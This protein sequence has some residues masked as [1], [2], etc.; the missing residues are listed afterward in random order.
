MVNDIL[1][2][3]G[4]YLIGSLSGALI[5]CSFMGLPDPRSQ[6]SG[7]PGA[8]NV[9]RHSG[10]TAAIFTLLVDVVKGVT[11]VL[12]AKFFTSSALILAST[13]LAVV[14]GHLYPLFFHFKGGKG[15]A[16]TFGA[17]VTL[18]WP[19]GL[20]A[21]TT[22]LVMAGLFRYSSLAALTAALLTPFYMYWFT[23]QIEYISLS[24]IL[25][26]LLIWRHRSNIRHLLSGQE[27]KF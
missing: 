24:V 26:S 15:V 5:V 22:W 7:N 16:T 1:L 13:T 10:K 23:G 19:V 3:F 20:S 14:L 11:A 25:S 17:L 27:G 6:G 12:I 21:L 18:A 8:T 2:V 4:A 9:L